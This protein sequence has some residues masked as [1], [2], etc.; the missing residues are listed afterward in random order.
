M[1]KFIPIWI[2]KGYSNK[3]DGRL[4]TPKTRLTLGL[5]YRNFL[6]L[7]CCGLN[8]NTFGENKTS[9]ILRAQK[10]YCKMKHS[11]Q[12]DNALTLFWRKTSDGKRDA[13]DRKLLLTYSVLEETML[14]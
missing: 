14:K 9:E 1:H 13:S 6:H 11:K 5:M 12:M 8:W 3:Q 2:L 4:L 10:K 7:M